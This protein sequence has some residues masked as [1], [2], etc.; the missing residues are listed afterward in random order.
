LIDSAVHWSFQVVS[1]TADEIREEVTGAF[2]IRS[3]LTNEHVVLES[4]AVKASDQPIERR[5]LQALSS[6]P[7]YGHLITEK[8]TMSKDI[9]NH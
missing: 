7:A 9:K 3:F 4:D 2:E 8:L 6:F 1:L 5:K